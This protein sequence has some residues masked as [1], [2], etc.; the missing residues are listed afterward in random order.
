MIADY[1]STTLW[2]TAFGNTGLQ[3]DR[4]EAARNDLLSALRKLEERVAPLLA[5]IDASCHEL[6]IHDITHV[7]QLW[8]V[9]SEICGPDYPLNPLEGFVLGAAFLIHD[10]GSYGRCL[11]GGTDWAS[12]DKLLPRPSRSAYAIGRQRRAR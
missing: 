11:S 9:A 5:K 3:N 10:A 6:T 1:K 8:S 2:A 4:Q 12:A 7:H